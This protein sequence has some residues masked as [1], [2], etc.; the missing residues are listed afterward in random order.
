VANTAVPALIN[1]SGALNDGNGKPLTGTVGVT[2]SLYKEDQGGAPLWLETQNV[3]ADRSGRYSV[4]LGSTRSTGVPADIFVAG[5][6]R[7]L[8]VQPAGQKELAR[9]MLLSVPYA[10]KA[11]DAQTIGGL[12][13]SA[14]VLAAPAATSAAAATSAWGSAPPPASNVTTSGGTVNTVPLWT[15]GTNI[16]SSV[17][18]QTGSGATAK[19]GVGT[20][21][22]TTTLDIH[23]GAAIRGVFSL[24]ATGNASATS[25]K[26]S[27]PETFVASS[28]SLHSRPD[29]SN[30]PLAGRAC[31]QQHCG[32][33]RN[34]E[35]SLRPR[36]GHPD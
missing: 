6:A 29:Q 28:F 26:P 8:S 5:E 16:Q 24:P 12:P 18:T 31:Q 4:V 36:R 20:A 3:Q 1:F 15:T 23:G 19:I 2:F 25:G 14:F 33:R 35:P 11:G 13:P 30:L 22:P 21:A 32:T 9:I 17:L 10:L 7:W 34:V 27:Q